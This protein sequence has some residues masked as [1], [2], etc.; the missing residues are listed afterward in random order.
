LVTTG[1]TILIIFLIS[2]EDGNLWV[3]HLIGFIVNLLV[4]FVTSIFVIRPR[5]RKTYTTSIAHINEE[6]ERKYT[7]VIK[8]QNP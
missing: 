5:L 3:S 7:E 6:V 8:N 2:K 4:W 1:F